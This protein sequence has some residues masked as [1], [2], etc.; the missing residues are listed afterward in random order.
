M[1]AQASHPICTPE[2]VVN[3]SLAV[4]WPAGSRAQAMFPTSQCFSSPP[5]PVL[6]LVAT[7]VVVLQ[8]M[9]PAYNGLVPS[10]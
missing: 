7:V 9:S 4:L 8:I 2:K 1:P 3:M 6:C 10:Q 5:S